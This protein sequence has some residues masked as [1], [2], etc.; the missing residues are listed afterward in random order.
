[1]FRA[2]PDAVSHPIRTY[3]RIDSNE[4]QQGKER[5]EAPMTWRVTTQADGQGHHSGVS[6]AADSRRGPCRQ[7]PGRL[8]DGSTLTVDIPPRFQCACSGGKTKQH[9]SEHQWD[10]TCK[11]TLLFAITGHLQQG[12]HA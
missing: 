9:H 10:T 2:I 7:C 11:A 3:T 8:V 4:M 5:G 12:Q 1:M 6:A